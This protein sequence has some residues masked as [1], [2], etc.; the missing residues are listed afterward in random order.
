MAKKNAENKK[1]KLL[2]K[3]KSPI[4]AYLKYSGMG[5]QMALII[6]FFSFLGVQLDKYFEVKHVFTVIFSLFGVALSM[7]VFISKIL[8]E[9]KNETEDELNS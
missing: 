6:V 7:Y 3:S 9:S 1:D 5:I 2:L 4:N 8:S